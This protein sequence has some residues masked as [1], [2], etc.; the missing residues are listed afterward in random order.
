MRVESGIFLGV[1]KERQGWGL[2]YAV[3]KSVESEE[4]RVGLGGRK[5]GNEGG[6]VGGG[7]GFV[8]DRN[9]VANI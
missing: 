5:D 3:C 1:R 6:F 9:D 4:L 2:I 8:L 7:G